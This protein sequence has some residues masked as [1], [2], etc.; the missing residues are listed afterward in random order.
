MLTLLDEKYYPVTSKFGFVRES[1]ATVA[2][3]YASDFVRHKAWFRDDVRCT[4]RDVAGP[5]A[6]MLEDFGATEQLLSVTNSV[7]LVECGEWVAC[8]ENGPRVHSTWGRFA[9]RDLAALNVTVASS[10]TKEYHPES[11]LDLV[12]S[13]R[14]RDG[15]VAFHLDVPEG[16]PSAYSRRLLASQFVNREWVW[17]ESGESLSFEEAK[18]YRREV[19]RERL[20]SLMVDAYCKELGIRPFDEEFYGQTGVVLRAPVM[21]KD[22]KLLGSTYAEVQANIP[23]FVVGEAKDYAEA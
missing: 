19:V 15:K 9:P 21:S 22:E 12:F 2:E 20:T 23:D 11:A 8:F 5:L 16:V 17:T 7:L 4:S 14:G 10:L 13:K 3:S 6:H 18:R 1:V